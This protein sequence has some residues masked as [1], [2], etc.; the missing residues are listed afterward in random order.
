MTKYKSI[1]FLFILLVGCASLDK[2]E[3]LK[4]LPNSEASNVFLVS[5][6]IY[7][8]TDGGMRYRGYSSDGVCSLSKS[9]LKVYKSSNPNSEIIA[10]PYSDIYTMNLII[11]D[12]GLGKSDSITISTKENKWNLSI[13]AFAV[14]N[15]NEGGL[16]YSSKT[17]NEFTGKYFSILKDNGVKIDNKLPVVD[18]SQTDTYYTPTYY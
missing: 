6:C 16:F 1:Y 15:E 4:G 9:G 14:K 5:Q 17:L 12:G 3:F 8:K 10:L 11:S 13:R 2:A 18:D 7:T